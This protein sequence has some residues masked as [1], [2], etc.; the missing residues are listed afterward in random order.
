MSFC[1]V[2]FAKQQTKGKPSHTNHLESKK[3]VMSHKVQLCIAG[4][5]TLGIESLAVACYT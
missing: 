3:R 5:G 1:I 2:L 4:D